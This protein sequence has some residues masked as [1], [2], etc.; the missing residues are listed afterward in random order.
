MLNSYLANSGLLFLQIVVTFKF[1][2]IVLT[3]WQTIVTSQQIMIIFLDVCRH[4]QACGV[5][6]DLESGN[7]YKTLG[8]YPDMFQ[9]YSLPFNV[10]SEVKNMN[11]L[12]SKSGLFPAKVFGLMV[13]AK[14]GLF[15]AKSVNLSGQSRIEYINIYMVS[16]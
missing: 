12:S 2:E 3:F 1:G 6:V 16:H 5:S 14:L 8:M 7:P 4:A 9:V 10:C 15:L 11:K 13:W